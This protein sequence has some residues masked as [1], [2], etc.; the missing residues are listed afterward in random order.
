MIPKAKVKSFEQRKREKQAELKKKE[1]N[2]Q[3]VLDS[4][5][6]NPKFVRLLNY[7]LNSLD[8]FITPPNHDIR[9]NAKIIIEKGGI[10]ILRNIA[11]KNLDNEE[12]VSRITE[13]IW[14]LLSV[15]DNVDQ[16]LAQLFVQAK[17]HEAII[18]LLLSK[19]KGPG[20]IPLIRCL[21]GLSQVPQLIG[22][23]LDSGLAET[24]KLV[25][26]MYSDDIG[27]IAMNFDTMLK[28]SNQKAGREFLI[29]KNL[30]PSILKNIT[31]C[32]EADTPEGVHCGLLVADNI[33]RNDE[34][35]AV[36][37]E[38]DAPHILRDVLD[39]FCETD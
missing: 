22:K 25:N 8:N 13:I 2:I 1:D 10:D 27:V 33:C 30:T 17:G 19:N 5:K 24:I 14:K 29:K 9:Q 23:L 35:K 4:A 28:I 12:V 39:N 18:E 20:S 37:K 3:N 21:N 15:Y 11:M 26:D 31:I 36:M 32:S 34:G 38:A 7:S 6:N 16:E